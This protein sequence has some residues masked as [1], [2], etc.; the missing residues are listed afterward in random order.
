MNENEAISKY[1]FAMAKE[2][3][4]YPGR[5]RYHTCN[6]THY[7]PIT[8]EYEYDIE[9]HV[10]AIIV[11]FMTMPD[12]TQKFYIPGT[13]GILATYPMLD[14]SDEATII[15]WMT[16]ILEHEDTNAYY[17]ITKR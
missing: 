8:Y 11:G 15:E 12:A 2:I 4:K 5:L 14:L 10:V 7:Y 6:A 9:T 3:A 16:K 1:L 17:N 13:G